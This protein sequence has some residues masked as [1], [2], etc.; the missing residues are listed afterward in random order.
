MNK[1]FNIT[2][3]ILFSSLG[4]G[5]S[6]SVSPEVISSSGDYFENSNSK[7]SWTIGEL[8][9]ETYQGT[10]ATLT[11]GFHQ[12]TN[13]LN[14][15]SADQIDITANIKIYP[16]PVVGNLN[17]ELGNN[18]NEEYNLLIIDFNGKLIFSSK[19]N[20][21]KFQTIDMSTYSHGTYMLTLTFKH[22]ESKTFQIIK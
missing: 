1:R 12:P 21:K 13:S 18:L 3:I 10:N 16:N 17:L 5:F 7:L 15:T 14:V 19:D 4:I 20:I 11:Q 8:S 22:S 6:Q 9:V 2:F